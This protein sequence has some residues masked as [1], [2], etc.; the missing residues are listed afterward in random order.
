MS[1]C[2]INI[3]QTVSLMFHSFITFILSYSMKHSLVLSGVHNNTIANNNYELS[4]TRPRIS[5]S[6][7]RES[8]PIF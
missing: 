5:Y 2:N 4:L 8:N 6:S 1:G 7:M 3:L